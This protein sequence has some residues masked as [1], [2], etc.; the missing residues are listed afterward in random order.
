MWEVPLNGGDPRPLQCVSY[1][2]R[3]LTNLEFDESGQFL[4]T[5]GGGTSAG[6]MVVALWRVDDLLTKKEGALANSRPVPVAFQLLPQS[7]SAVTSLKVALN[8]DA[9]LTLALGTDNGVK[10]FKAN[11]EQNTLTE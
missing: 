10:L 9:S 8:K 2:Q 6:N 3:V 1:H 4:A 7:A 11:L 5:V